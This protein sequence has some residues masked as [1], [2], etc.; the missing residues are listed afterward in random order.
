MR[1]LPCDSGSGES[2]AG[3]SNNSLRFT[4]ALINVPVKNEA[5]VGDKFISLQDERFFSNY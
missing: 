2:A 3:G 5:E 1:L 4:K